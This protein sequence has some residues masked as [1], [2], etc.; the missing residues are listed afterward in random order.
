MN[1]FLDMVGVG[2]SSLLGRTKLK[3]LAFMQG[4]FVWP[5][6]QMRI[7]EGRST[8]L[9]GAI[10]DAHQAGPKGRVSGRYEQSTRSYQT[11]NTSLDLVF[12]S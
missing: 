2:S 8:K 1:K 6:S 11:E 12:I 3:R 4:V 10:L 5:D 9:P 7:Y